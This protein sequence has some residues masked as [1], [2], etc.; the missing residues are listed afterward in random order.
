MRDLLAPETPQEWRTPERICKLACM[1][2][3]LNYHD[4]AVELLLHLVNVHHWPLEQL[5]LEVVRTYVPNDLWPEL[6][7]LG[8]LERKITP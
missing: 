2:D 4:Y 8:Y 5:L 3:V 1:M 6:P 7:L